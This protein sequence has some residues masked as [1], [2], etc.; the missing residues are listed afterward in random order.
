MG[1]KV[2]GHGKIKDVIKRWK[3][4]DIKKEKRVRRLEDQER[5]KIRQE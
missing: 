3:R 1:A 2:K 4:V 5:E